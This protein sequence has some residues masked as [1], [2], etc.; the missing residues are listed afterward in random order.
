MQDF[1]AFAKSALSFFTLVI[2][3]ESRVIFFHFS[4][5]FQKDFLCSIFSKSLITFFS[6]I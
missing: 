2:L 3:I 6:N 4:N 1:M 5:L